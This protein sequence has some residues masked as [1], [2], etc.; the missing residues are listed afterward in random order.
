MVLRFTSYTPSVRKVTLK[1]NEGE[2]DNSGYSRGLK[3]TDEVQI[4]FEGLPQDK[5]G[6]ANNNVIKI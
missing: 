1:C 5:S 6:K 3:N 2:D 4:P